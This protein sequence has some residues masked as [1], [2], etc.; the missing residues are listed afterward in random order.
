MA[1]AEAGA[2]VTLVARDEATLKKARSSLPTPASQSHSYLRHDTSDWANVDRV[3]ADDIDANGPIEILINN[4]GGPAPGLAIEAEPSAFDEAFDNHILTGQTLVKAIVP[5]MKDA[6]YGRI[7]NIISSSVVTPLANLG[8]SNTIRGAV[9]QWGRTLATELA[10]YGIT[11][12]NILP[13]SIDTARL[14]AT[15]SRNAERLGQSEGDVERATVDAIPAGRLGQPRDIGGV[16]AFLA[17]PA[18][19]Y[20]TGVNLAVDG[21]RTAVQ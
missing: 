15:M 9:A 16:A 1:L 11:V 8:V 17:S 4:T 20:V 6:G 10:P 7:I 21:G 19:S 3:L 14:R 2:I 12:N 5:G 18:A 13:G